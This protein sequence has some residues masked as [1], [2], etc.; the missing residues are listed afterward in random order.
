[1]IALLTWMNTQG[2]KL[3]KLVQNVFTVA[4]TGALLALIV[5][6]IVVGIGSHAA[7]ANFGDL[8]TVRGTLTDVG[9]GHLTAAIA[10]G[11]FVG[12]CVAQTQSLFSADAWNN[13]TFTA[14]EVKDPRRNIP[15]AL[16]LGMV[17]VI[18]IYLL[19]NIAYLVTLPFDQVQHAASDRVATATLE[20]IFPGLGGTIMAI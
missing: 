7:H 19:A 9:P 15:L 4:K 1:M 20:A 13:I 8:W 5:L 2:L 3:G 10:F 12:I 14:G 16:A 11:L 6:G 17:I 18:A